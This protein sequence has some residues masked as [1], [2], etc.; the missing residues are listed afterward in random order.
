M[1]EQVVNAALSHSDD[2][3]NAIGGSP[4][5][6]LIGFGI[7]IGG[8]VLMVAFQNGYV[9][10]INCTYGEMQMGINARPAAMME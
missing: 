4:V 5:H 9:I 2:I 6:K 8:G 7:L 10:N 3:L 1:T